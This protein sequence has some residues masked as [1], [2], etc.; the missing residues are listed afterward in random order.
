MKKFNFSEI[1]KMFQTFDRY[2]SSNEGPCLK[3]HRK[4]RMFFKIER[5][6][7]ISKFLSFSKSSFFSNILTLFRKIAPS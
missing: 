3:Y 6:E 5:S 2:C 4:H 7:I 1:H